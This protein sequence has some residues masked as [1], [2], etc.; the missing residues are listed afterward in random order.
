[1]FSASSVT[2][3]FCFNA[4]PNQRY[5]QLHVF[6]KAINSFNLYFRTVNSKEDEVL[7]VVRQKDAVLGQVTVPVSN[8]YGIKGRMQKQKLQP[9]KKCSRP[10]GEL[11][12][13]CFVSHYRK[14]DNPLPERQSKPN[15]G[16][17]KSRSSSN[18]KT[19]DI[20]L[21]NKSTH[22]N[23]T[24]RSNKTKQTVTLNETS[25][26]EKDKIS[27]RVPS[28]PEKLDNGINH[29]DDT[30][31]DT[32]DETPRSSI[33]S[34][35]GINSREGKNS[36]S[37]SISSAH[38]VNSVDAGVIQ[39]KNKR[40]LR[41]LFSNKRKSGKS[42]NVSSKANNAEE[43]KKERPDSGSGV[44]DQT[45]KESTRSDLTSVSSLNS[46]YSEN[47]NMNNKRNSVSF[48]HSDS[49]LSDDEADHTSTSGEMYI[50]SPEQCSVNIIPEKN[51]AIT[52][53]TFI[54]DTVNNSLKQSEYKSDVEPDI[55]DLKP[56]KDCTDLEPRPVDTDAD[57]DTIEEKEEW[58]RKS[59]KK[60]RKF[61][62]GFLSR[63]SHDVSIAG[64]SLEI[65]TS[66]VST[67]DLTELS[68]DKNK[69]RNSLS[70]FGMN[71]DQIKKCPK[72]ISCTPNQAPVDEPRRLCIEGFNLGTEKSDILSLKV[73][74]CDCLDTIEFKTPSMIYCK[75]HFQFEEHT[76]PV[77]IITKSGGQGLLEDGFTFY[78][79]LAKFTPTS[80][81]YYF[82]DASST[83]SATSKHSPGRIDTPTVTN[84]PGFFNRENKVGHSYVHLQYIIW[85]RDTS[86]IERTYTI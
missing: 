32:A 70:L 74:G 66:S 4:L 1:M 3:Y 44:S 55:P 25:D 84:H 2:L 39:N 53:N 37:E 64:K 50:E 34:S 20:E 35:Q 73:A 47:E 82:T 22:I 71:T 59:D 69:R 16:I 68:G 42:K 77:E 63:S 11:T 80:P 48:D 78:D 45:E 65:F 18:L 58:K 29:L 85:K 15:K 17:S 43:K 10:Q 62:L 56:D 61:S 67:T 9:H 46:H 76:G 21:E 5:W 52:D 72:I 83:G 31:H 13:Q 54:N 30:N 40:R 28:S 86:Q 12:Y 57:K 51:K 38:K 60:K 36:D 19:N 8:I 33:A 24:D 6:L 75:T 7:F 27:N 41:S 26:S 49:D 79:E 81:K 23:Q 14:L